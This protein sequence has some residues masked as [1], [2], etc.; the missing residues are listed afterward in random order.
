MKQRHFTVLEKRILDTSG[1]EE[2]DIK[3]EMYVKT[4]CQG[5][6]EL[7]CDWIMGVYDVSPEELAQVF[8]DCLPLPLH[9]YLL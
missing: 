2:L 5:T 4:Y 9:K 1:K 6:V 8:E 3:T 7:I